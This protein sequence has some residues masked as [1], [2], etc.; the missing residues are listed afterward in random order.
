MPVPTITPSPTASAPVVEDTSA[1]GKK[2]LF[3]ATNEATI[4]AAGG[5]VP[6]GEAFIDALINAGFD[7]A[8]MQLTPDKT[9]INLDADNVQFSVLIEGDCLIG[10]YGNVGYQSVVLPALSSGLCLIGKTRPINW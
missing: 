7:V 4:A 1:N 8:A 10:Q 2:E 6:G 5:A 9:A 3:D